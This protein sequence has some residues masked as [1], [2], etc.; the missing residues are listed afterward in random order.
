MNDGVD[1]VADDVITIAIQDE[2]NNSLDT[3]MF[4]DRARLAPNCS[5]D[6]GAD[7]GLFASRN[8]EIVG[9][10]GVNN[11]LTIDLIPETDSIERYD[12][13]DNGWF[14]TGGVASP[15]PL[16]PIEVHVHQQQDE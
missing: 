10:R 14:P 6:Q 8:F 16:V 13:A 5:T 9:H 12:A 3:V 1:A 11:T 4:I 15:V 7:T 2:N